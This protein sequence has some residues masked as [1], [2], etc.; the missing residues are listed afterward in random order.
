VRTKVPHSTIEDAHDRRPRAPASASLPARV[1]D[2]PRPS[3]ERGF[4]KIQRYWDPALAH[5]N[6]KILPG[7]YYVTRSEEVI[8]TVLGSCISACIRD[9]S[10]RVGGMNHFMLPEDSSSGDGNRWLDPVAGLATRYGTHAM[11]SLINELM[12]LG[13]TRSRF[14]IKLFGAG[15]ILASVTDVGARNIEFVH[16]FLKTEGLR[17]LA[18]DLGDIFP[19]RVAYFPTTGKVKVRRLRP[20]D[21]TAI[22]EQERKYLTDIGA[23]ASQGGD[24]ELFD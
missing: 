15:R 24:V 21:A 16:N 7:E 17:A 8:T 9:P 11:E 23:G 14:E 22:A 19:R 1:A 12:K 4:E 5:W 20:L 10:A 18:E 6:A 3:A 13:G 2:V